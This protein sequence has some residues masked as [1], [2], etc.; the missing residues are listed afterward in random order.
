MCHG[1]ETVLAEA[2]GG[3]Q[4][5]IWYELE[6]EVVGDRIRAF[7]DGHQVF[8]L[9]DPNLCFGKAGIVTATRAQ[10]RFDDFLIQTV[11]AFEDDFSE[12][13]AGRWRVLRGTW[14]QRREGNRH[15]RVVSAGEPAKAVAGSSRWSDH[16]L[17]AIARLPAALG[18]TS[19]AGLVGHYLDETNYA[20][21]AWRPAAG[22]ARL[23]AVA[24]G[25]RTALEEVRAPTGLPSSRHRLRLTW[26][27]NVVTAELDGHPLASAWV[28]KL[29]RGKVG[30]YAAAV[31][32]LAFENA[33]VQFPLRRQPVLTTN[34][35]FSRESSMEIWAGAARDWE[36]TRESIQGRSVSAN[37]HRADF[38]GDATIE[39]DIKDP[40]ARSAPRHGAARTCHL[41]L[42]GEPREL[43]ARRRRATARQRGIAGYEFAFTWP[44]DSKRRTEFQAAILRHGQTVAA[45]TVALDSAPQRL[46]FRRLGRHL[47][48]SVDNDQTL[49]YHDPQPLDGHRA[50]YATE[51]FDVPKAQVRV[52]SDTVQVYTF[53]RASSAWRPAAGRWAISNRWQCDPR[54][55]FFSGVPRGGSRLA[56][57]WNKNIYDGDLSV[58]FAVGPKMER[59]RGGSYQYARDFNVTIAAD[60][61]DLDTGYSF[62]YGGWDDSYTAITRRGKVVKRTSHRIRR[63]S[64]IHR[65]WFYIKVEKIGPT[66]TYTIDGQP[67]LTYTDPAP[68]P[69]RQVA[70]WSWDCGIMVSRVRISASRILGTE[71]PGLP[72]GRCHTIYSRRR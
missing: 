69:G 11:R 71:P 39:L 55:S 48:A 7:I 2:P 45:R 65:R 34:E 41:I 70:I 42:S 61:N 49:A 72:R 27:H 43:A 8:S 26:S 44:T 17:T 63:S 50:A 36:S 1:R 3:Y 32:G 67:V 64:S 4:P 58:E 30:L 33:R 35:V 13:A 38:F 12:L 31:S 23:E 14:E 60:G 53:S 18:E 56:A 46:S 5:E 59:E 54:W 29:P 47:I 57:L 62:I 28:P 25:Q 9:T 10:A 24:D 51:G 20:L 19:E 52:F 37:W 15:L 22:T 6:A 68:L 16:T 21:F 40:A 66:L